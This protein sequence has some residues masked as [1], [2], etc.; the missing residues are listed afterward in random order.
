MKEFQ[1][2]HNAFELY[3]SN[4]QSNKTKSE[5]IIG[6][7]S[8]YNVANSTIWRW[9]KEFNWDERAHIRNIEINKQV[10]KKTNTVIADNKAK[11]LT[12]IHKLLDDWKKKVDNGEVPVEIKSPSDVDKIIKLALLL[13]DEAGEIT[14]NQITINKEK[15]LERLRKIEAQHNK[16]AMITNNKP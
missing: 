5:S 8:E 2:H 9:H 7:A 3:F 14:E 13:Q 10:E 4:I 15:G 1:R 6:V 12:F 16:R 11:Y